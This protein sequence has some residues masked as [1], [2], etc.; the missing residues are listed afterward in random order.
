MNR[1]FFS[2]I[3]PVYNREKFI[4]RALDSVL[5]QSFKDFEVI[6]VNNGSTDQ[7]LPII[8]DYAEKD[9]RIKVFDQ[10][11]RGRSA[12]RNRGLENA[13]GEWI[14]FLDSD[15]FYYENHLVSIKSLIQKNSNQKAFATKLVQHQ[16]LSRSNSINELNER[17]IRLADCIKSNPISLI[18]LCL[19]HDVAEKLRFHEEDLPIAEDWLFIRELLMKATIFKSNL[20]TVEVGEHEGRSMRTTDLNRIAYYNIRSSELFVKRNSVHGRLKSKILSW[21]YLLGAHLY[22]EGDD[23]ARAKTMI[24]KSMKFIDSWV[25][26]NLYWFWLKY[27]ANNLIKNQSK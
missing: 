17:E 6:C 20:P 1:P 8:T 15:D 10:A 9:S 22:L 14:C 13:S 19:H 11:N 21:G 18:Q 23:K 27:F 7:T 4:G 25:V 26:Y 2:V 3:I 24:L 5:K 12:A 16:I